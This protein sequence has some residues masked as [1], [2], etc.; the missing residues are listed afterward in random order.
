MKK[1]LLLLCIVPFLT[2][3][4]R[5]TDQDFKEIAEGLARQCPMVLDNFTTGMSVTYFDKTMTYIY[6]IDKKGYKMSNSEFMKGMEEIL[7]NS[8][9]TAP[10]MKIYKDHN[11]N[12][13]WIYNDV[14]GNYMGKV[15]L[16]KD[17]CF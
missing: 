16:N 14:R 10:D 6:S 4:Q 2:F 8:F 13:V 9:C 17:D 11:I 12:M 15:S 1:L 7:T 5:L 3:G